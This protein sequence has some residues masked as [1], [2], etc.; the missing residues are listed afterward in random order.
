M[1]SFN[2]H[3][4]KFSTTRTSIWVPAGDGERTTESLFKLLY[5]LGVTNISVF[6][7][8]YDF[9]GDNSW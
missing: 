5:K 7:N 4:G 3:E 1:R 9:I 8:T 2:Y 6:V